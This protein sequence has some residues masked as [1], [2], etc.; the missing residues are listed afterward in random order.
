MVE[1]GGLAV[2]GVFSTAAESQEYALVV[3]AMN[4][5]C[6]IKMEAETGRFVIFAEPAYAMAISDEFGLYA[7]EQ[8]E[9]VE[10]I[11]VPLFKS[12]A[13][14]A[15]LWITSLLVV[16]GMQ[17]ED[18]GFTDRFCNS[19]MAVI[20]GGEWWRPFTSL[21]LHGDV[22]HMVG[23]IGFGVIFCILV[24][25][26]VG[27]VLGWV[28]ILASGAIGNLLTAAVRYPEEFRSVGASTATFGALGILVGVG[29]YVSWQARSYRKLG[30][31]LVP[32]G[33]GVVML[34]W[35]GAGGEN[36]DVAAHVAGFGVGAL[37]GLA[38]SWRQMRR[39]VVGGVTA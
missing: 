28:L 37:L 24:A 29:A 39:Q 11:E 17:G 3:L 36:T 12:G 38:A 4:L 25:H 7:A 13:E 2:V 5:D 30:A 19:S 26:T 23:N 31:A 27:P 35:F 8:E 18:A 21:F 15:I 33:A 16:F 9:R 1:D 14:L 32:V 6:W 10:P 20:E 34:G 22:N